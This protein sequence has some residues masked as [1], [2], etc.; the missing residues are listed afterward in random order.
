VNISKISRILGLIRQNYLIKALGSFSSIQ[1]IGTLVGLIVISLYTKLLPAEE[2]GKITMLTVFGAIISILSE[3]GLIAAFSI[4]FYKVSQKENATNIYSILLYMFGICSIL[5]ILFLFQPGLF[6][7][8]SRVHLTPGSISVFFLFVITGLIGRFYTN[9]LMISKSP[10]KYFQ[11]NLAFYL[12]VLVASAVYLLV[13]R[14][15][16]MS[17]LY[18]YLWANCLLLFMG[19]RFFLLNYKPPDKDI[20]SCAG[21]RNLLKIGTPLVPNSFMLMLLTYADRYILEKYKGLSEVGIYSVGY[22][23][24]DKINSLI[25]NPIGQA[26]SPL[27][28]ELYA[29]FPDEYRELVKNVFQVFWLII[30][31]VFVGYFVILREIFHLLIGSEYM[32]GYNIVPIVLAGVVFEGAGNLLGGTIIMKEKTDKMF[33]LTGISVLLNIGLNFIMIPPYGM[34]GAAV[35]TLISCVIHFLMIL[36]YTQHLL[37]IPFDYWLIFKSILIT[38]FFAIPV[39]ALSY[40]EYHPLLRI[41]IKSIFFLLQVLVVWKFLGLRE[42]ITNVLH[43]GK[44]NKK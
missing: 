37:F 1:I 26:F 3:T 42:A 44:E 23:F 24:A 41:C 12:I 16:F 2:Y 4:K 36:T 30:G 32:L 11:I 25:I 38:I 27:S 43:Y 5:Y 28:F 7:K 40:L 20:F 22:T 29:R 35:A 31:M 9:F 8:F 6:S 39:L 21:L 34:Y 17:Y 10:K 18:S 19:I 14:S 15:G 13:L 33:L